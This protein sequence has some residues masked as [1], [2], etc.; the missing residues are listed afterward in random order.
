MNLKSRIEELIT[1]V[2]SCSTEAGVKE[3]ETLYTNKKREL[4]AAITPM[5][6]IRVRDAI[7]GKLDGFASAAADREAR[8]AAKEKEDEQMALAA[9]LDEGLHVVSE[10]DF[11]KHN[12]KVDHT[13]IDAVVMMEL[14]GKLPTKGHRELYSVLE[15]AAE[16]VGGYSQLLVVDDVNKSLLESCVGEYTDVLTDENLYALVEEHI[17]LG[18]SRI[19]AMVE[20]CNIPKY[21]RLGKHFL[22]NGG[23]R[24]EIVQVKNKISEGALDEF[25]KSDNLLEFYKALPCE[26][27][28]AEDLFDERLEEL[29]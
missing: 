7:A 28:E 23:H 18:V 15:D 21:R 25:V 9:K 27:K 10:K 24:F 29:L 26:L 11:F 19:F 5:M 14:I 1:S 22:Q 13:A 12:T 8:K 2:H 6:D 3:I 20:E 17:R 16:H 4:G